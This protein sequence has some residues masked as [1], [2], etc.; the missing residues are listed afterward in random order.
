MLNAIATDFA[1]LPD[2]HVA[3][4]RD[5]RL[6]SQAVPAANITVHEV[7]SFAAELATF[8]RLVAASDAV[9]LIA[10]EFAVQLE[11]RAKWVEQAGVR[12]LSPNSRF[13]QL[14]ADKWSS[15]LMLWKQN[16]P[17]PPAVLVPKGVSLPSYLVYPIVLKPLDGCGSLGVQYLATPATQLDW[18]DFTSPEA[19]AQEYRSG[20]AAS[21]AVLSGPTAHYYLP[22]CKQTLSRDGRF[23]YLGGVT[24]L[25]AVL[26]RRAETLAAQV[27]AALPSTLGYFGIDL[28]FGELPEEDRVIEINPRLTTS[29]LGLRA[30][31]ETSLAAAMLE[32]QHGNSLNLRFGQEPITF[33]ADG[34]VEQ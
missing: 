11:T 19:I 5:A 15:H 6:A 23:Q 1:A 2:C 16:V 20:M 21:I 28:I 30:I 3:I 9:L 18:S 24:P 14:T 12:L 27:V 13:I 17:V 29:Y 22:A 34:R 33:H 8:Q 25:H 32:M 7:A 31:S 10:P 4:M 26:Q